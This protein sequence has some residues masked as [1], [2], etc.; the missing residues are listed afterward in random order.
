MIYFTADTHFYHA[1]IIHLCNRPFS[2][3]TEMNRKLTQ[4]WNAYITD[5]DE[6][7]IL[8]DFIYK[9]T[10]EEAA[11]IIRKLKGKKYLIKGNHDLFL[12]D[13]NFNTSVFEWIKDYHILVYKKL[14]LV[15]FHYPIL[16]WQGFFGNALHLYGHVHNAQK[17][18]SQAE[19][20]AILGERAV[21]VGVD[22]N[23]FFP[24]SIESIIKNTEKSDF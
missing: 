22:V 13:A 16:E 21:N 15:L 6:V 7:Y 3:I 8:G 20:F 11:Q 1:N 14:K 4:N 17:D 24:V 12:E 2:D 10:A 19:R 23:N 18:P 9:S 5:K